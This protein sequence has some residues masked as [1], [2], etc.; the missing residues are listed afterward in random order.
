MRLHQ[1]KAID[2]LRYVYGGNLDHVRAE[3]A[4]DTRSVTNHLS[5]S[6]PTLTGAI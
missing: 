4:L 5:N 3:K 6:Q 2:M 1:V